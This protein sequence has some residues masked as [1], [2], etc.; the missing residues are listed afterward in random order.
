MHTDI[1]S[2]LLTVLRKT[3]AGGV[4]VVLPQG[5][6]GPDAQIALTQGDKN[7]NLQ[8]QARIEILHLNPI[9]V[10]NP[11]EEVARRHPEPQLVEVHEADDV[12]S[13]RV[14]LV[15]IA[16]DNPLRLRGIHNRT[17][18]PILNEPQRNLLDEAGTTPRIRRDG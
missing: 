8:N 13:R 2:P 10:K 4:E 15:F 14:R 16:R 7:H 18:E 6:V 12:T 3:K 9:M 5:K 1:I 17:E 11:T